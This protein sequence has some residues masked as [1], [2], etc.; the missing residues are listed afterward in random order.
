[1][2]KS[3]YFRSIEK[4]ESGQALALK[5]ILDELSFNDNGLVWY[6][7]SLKMPSAEKY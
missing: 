5:D 6:L 2:M 3:I 7:L 1:M 4:V